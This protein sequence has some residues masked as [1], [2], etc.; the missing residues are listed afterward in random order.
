LTEAGLGL[1]PFVMN[2]G[3]AGGGLLAFLVGGVVLPIA[4]PFSVFFADTGAEQWRY[5][6]ASLVFAIVFALVWR[7][8]A[9]KER[10]GLQR[11][12]PTSQAQSS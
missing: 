3:P 1:I 5:L 12:E 8:L 7:I 2:V 11:A 9:N 4:A 10:D 6:V